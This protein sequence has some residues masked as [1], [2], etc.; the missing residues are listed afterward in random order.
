MLLLG[1]ELDVNDEIWTSNRVYPAAYYF[2]YID[3]TK[4]ISHDKNKQQKNVGLQQ[5]I[6]AKL[7]FFR[8][9]NSRLP[10]S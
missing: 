4:S 10:G 3:L 9:M 1:M 7:Y 5:E 6:V 8:V 2:S